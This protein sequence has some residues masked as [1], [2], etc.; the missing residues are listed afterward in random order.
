MEYL[1]GRMVDESLVNLQTI[2]LINS[3]RR[4]RKDNDFDVEEAL[5]LVDRQLEEEK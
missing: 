3:K 5:V 2:D 4:F 1:I